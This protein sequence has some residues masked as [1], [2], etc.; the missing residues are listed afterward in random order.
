MCP[1]G[2]GVPGAVGH[3]V[4]SGCEEGFPA[5]NQIPM[6]LLSQG[7]PPAPP[8]PA[9][10][11][12]ARF[13]PFIPPAD[14]AFSESGLDGKSPVTPALPRGSRQGHPPSLELERAWDAPTL[15]APTHS[16]GTCGV[17]CS[18]GGW[19]WE[20]GM[21]GAGKGER[22]RSGLPALIIF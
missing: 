5:M 6:A 21:A 22:Q 17:L 19:G 20:G 18:G 9:M 3:A 13:I 2:A 8:P 1:E 15:A 10:G 14:P 12:P 4:P 7:P 16:P 11:S